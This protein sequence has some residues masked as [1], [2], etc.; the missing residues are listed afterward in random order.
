MIGMGSNKQRGSIA[1]KAENKVEIVK[2]TNDDS[3]YNSSDILQLISQSMNSNV[4]SYNDVL[5]SSDLSAATTTTS[6]S[7]SK[8]DIANLENKIK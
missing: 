7:I 5:S 6:K 3:D 8:F 2:E 4:S 1:K